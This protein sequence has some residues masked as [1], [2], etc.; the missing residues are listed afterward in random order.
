MDAWHALLAALR[1]P[2]A[3]EVVIVGVPGSGRQSL[4]RQALEQ[5]SIGDLFP[6]GV[7]CAEG[8]TPHPWLMGCAFSEKFSSLPHT[9]SVAAGAVAW[10]QRSRALVI[11]VD[12][13]LHPSLPQQLRG[14]ASPQ[15]SKLVWL[16]EDPTL[17]PGALAITPRHP[18]EAQTMARW[19]QISGVT[20][21]SPAVRELLGRS[22]GQM[23]SLRLLAGL[24]RDHDASH[25]SAQLPAA[26]EP[27]ALTALLRLALGARSAAEQR[28][29]Q[30]A[31]LFPAGFQE[32]AA[33]ITTGLEMAQWRALA[34]FGWCHRT[35]DAR[36]QLPAVVRRFVQRV[37]TTDEPAADFD[38]WLAYV[39][40]ELERGLTIG[41]DHIEVGARELATLWSESLRRR[42]YPGWVRRSGL[43]NHWARSTNHVLLMHD[44]HT[45]MLAQLQREPLAL[46][47]VEQRHTRAKLLFAI[48]FTLCNL[49]HLEDAERSAHEGLALVTDHPQLRSDGLAM[50][51][52]SIF[53]Q[54]RFAE[55]I[56]TYREALAA[57]A[58]GHEDP[59][60]AANLLADLAQARLMIGDL[61]DAES[62]L[63]QAIALKQRARRGGLALANINALGLLLIALERLDEAFEVL[64][65]G[66]QQGRRLRSRA[67][68]PYLLH[69]LALVLLETGQ[70]Q[71]AY[72][73]AT[74]AFGN[75]D[76]RLHGQVTPL[77]ETTLTRTMAQSP[78]VNLTTHELRAL[79]THCRAL[80]GGV[81]WYASL[82]AIDYLDH[83]AGRHAAACELAQL[84]AAAPH[85][86]HLNTIIRR[87]LRR[88]GVDST[89]TP[90]APSL[91]ELWH[92]MARLTP[93]LVAP[94]E[95]H[96][97]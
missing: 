36:W 82:A 65:D 48:S 93:E 42:D 18:T 12:G 25:L 92:A 81:A 32:R 73:L 75:L 33:V 68:L 1:N 41:F 47:A 61:D 3:T 80:G 40:Q 71:E 91:D 16:E 49:Q 10:L 14:V 11:I 8:H 76:P 22:D 62:A 38:A 84:L 15:G 28:A 66:V 87:T 85:E 89:D 83:Q 6:D 4:V 63:R 35:T 51:A 67:F 39:E 26:P 9:L 55:A 78:G 13:A 77:L 19:Q 95:G 58:I 97:G 2:D 88:L 27:L 53:H 37:L 86:G 74:E 21:P 20:D 69:S 46:P 45:V 64:H 50:V 52:S 23:L 43:L 59:L 44:W 56:D 34:A 30:R 7:L 72:R 17:L 29:L 96:A 94:P 57:L 24:L 90:P 5:P 31:S 70:P 54:D 60:R 79:L